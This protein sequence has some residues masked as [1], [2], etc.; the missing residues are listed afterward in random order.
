MKGLK[1][2]ELEGEKIELRF[3]GG[4]ISFLQKFMKKHKLDDE[5]MES[6]FMMLSLAE[7]FAKGDKAYQKP[8]FLEK[9]EENRFKY[10][11]LGIDEITDIVSDLSDV[12]DVVDKAKKKKQSK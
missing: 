11:L 1:T 5:D 8:D 10:M 3:C 7:L 12:G 4:V 2:I 6:S 9:A